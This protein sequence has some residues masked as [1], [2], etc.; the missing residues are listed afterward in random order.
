MSSRVSEYEWDMVT[1]SI[2]GGSPK[3]AAKA[4]ASNPYTPTHV[5]NALSEF[6]GYLQL[7]IAV[8]LELLRNPSLSKTGLWNI[9]RA[10]KKKPREAEQTIPLLAAHENISKALSLEIL[11]AYPYRAF[12][13][14][15]TH[16]TYDSVVLALIQRNPQCLN[17]FAGNRNLTLPQV[18]LIEETMPEEY[19]VEDINA[20][21]L[22]NQWFIIRKYMKVNREDFFLFHNGEKV[23][24]RVKENPKKWRDV[25]THYL[26]Y[27]GYEEYEGLENMPIVWLEQ[28]LETVK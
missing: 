2:Y 28:L 4:L 7:D 3:E 9:Y 23:L 19:R 27:F 21:Y 13:Q 10:Y 26:Q 1:D 22:H 16:T 8:A 6:Q 11:K 18:L 5:L 20:E 15:A 17:F 24:N 14:L 25:L 12:N